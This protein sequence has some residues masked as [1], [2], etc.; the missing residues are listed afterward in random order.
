MKTS[1]GIKLAV[2]ATLV[3]LLSALTFG[4]RTPSRRDTVDLSRLP[5]EIW[6][7]DTNLYWILDGES[8][9]VC[10]DF[11]YFIRQAEE[12]VRSQ[13]VRP[14]SMLITDQV[15]E[16]TRRQAA[17]SGV[18]IKLVDRTALPVPQESMLILRDAAGPSDMSFTRIPT[19]S[20][21]S[22]PDSVLSVVRRFLT[23]KGAFDTS[24]AGSNP[25]KG[26]STIARTE[27][28]E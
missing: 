25:P 20:I 17:I 14:T 16:H 9:S 15:D 21:P 7:N 26:P 28:R 10:R 23:G 6:T 4:T 18:A 2:P 12:V 11:V 8:L 22:F 24:S 5:E 3:L 27:S 1:T 13:S 19:E